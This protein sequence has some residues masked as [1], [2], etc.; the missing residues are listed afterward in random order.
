MSDVFIRPM[1]SMD[2]PR[3]MQIEHASYTSPWPETSFRG[4]LNR[5]DSSLYVAESDNEVAGYAACWAVLE[6][7]ELGNIAV[8]PEHR[9][10]GVARRLMDAVVE[11]MRG[12]GVREL[13]LEVRVTNTSAQRLY[14]AYGFKQVA[15]RPGYYTNPVEDA[16]VMCKRL[17]DRES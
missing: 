8:A 3:V 15:R 11:D 10:K 6:Q 12:R 4:L 1:S 13:Y 7:G 16:L 17:D 2:L 14:E 9:R 5:S